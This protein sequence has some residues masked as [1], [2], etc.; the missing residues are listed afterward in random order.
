MVHEAGELAKKIFTSMDKISFMKYYAL[1]L[2]VIL[3]FA[4]FLAGCTQS[5]GTRQVT[6]VVTATTIPTPEPTTPVQRLVITTAPP[7]VVTIVHQVSLTKDIKDSELLFTL[8]VP[9]EWSV[10]T[11]RLINPAD[12]EGLVY[13]TDLVGN[14]VFSIQTYAISRSQDQAY[15]DLFRK[16][17]PAPAETTVTM[18]EITYDRFES[19]SGGKTNV[20]YVT[21]K[22]SA[23]ERGYASVLVFSADNS[24]RFEKDD[25]EKIVASFKYFSAGSASAMPGDEIQRTDG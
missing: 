4:L 16:W 11:H 9:E 12:S 22:S 6:P 24:N 14:N 1:P 23:N 15:R 13:Q 20:A 3:V 2:I 19:T 8:Q 25:F 10:S 18:N 21:R 17:S 7:Q 5:P